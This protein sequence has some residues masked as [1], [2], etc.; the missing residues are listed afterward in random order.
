[1]RIVQIIDSLE[2]GGAERM[3]VSYAN[4]LVE[5]IE[6]SGL[7]A[8]RK[9]GSLKNQLDSK[10][11]YL[12]LKRNKKIDFLAVFRMRNYLI[13]NQIDIIH[14]HGS[15]FFIAVLVKFTLPRIKVIWHD[16]YGTRTKESKKDNRILVFL[17][18]FF[19]SILVVNL[20]L[21]KWSKENMK[22]SNV[23][24]I[25]N[26]AAFQSVSKQG[27]KLKGLEG[28][29]IVFLANLK[30]PKNHILILKA[31]QA[32][33]LNETGWSLHL[34]GKDY[35]DS[36]SDLI[37]GFIKSHS[38]KDYIHIY[39][40]QNDIKHILLQT[41]IG[42]LASTDEGF[43]VTLLEYGLGGLGVV[44]TNVG[45]CS[46]IIK[47]DVNGL[48]FDPSSE[49]EVKEQLLKMIENE[50]FRMDLAR[51]F[52]QSILENYSEEIVIDK[53]IIQYEKLKR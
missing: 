21:E 6:F 20:E 19:S 32:L 48:L 49:F 39:G 52:K 27:I 38:L 50:V 26:F 7:I 40:V 34:I 36:Y 41:S 18:T 23:S 29:R 4:A 37:K 43:P 17:S 24:F 42:V 47:N 3:A 51:N 2:A 33:R 12:F 22:C 28:K 30:K 45:Y 1:M 25:P 11:S 35:L 15:S 31:F 46:K 8:T 10:V 14:A 9:E 13:K 53:L 16:H 5:K 44:S